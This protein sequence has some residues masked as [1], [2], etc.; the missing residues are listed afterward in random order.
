MNNPA[1]VISAADRLGFTV[2]LATAFHVAIILGIGFALPDAADRPPTL[3]IILAQQETEVAPEKADYLAQ[4]NQ[5][6]SGELEERAAPTTDVEA[7][8]EAEEIQEIVEPEARASTAEVAPPVKQ[9]LAAT[10]PQ[11]EKVSKNPT[12]EQAEETRELDAE[13]LLRRSMEI[14]S[15]EAQLDLQRQQYARN[16]RIRRLTSA[17]TQ[18]ASDAWYLEAWR[19]KIEMVGNL[20]YPDEARR[21]RIYGSLR[22]LVTLK[23]DGSV[24]DIRILESSGHKLLD[25]AAIRIVRLAE[26]FA[27]FPEEM[28][29]DVDVLEVIR[30]WQFR[31]TLTSY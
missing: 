22:M 6:G 14:A 20:N 18:K 26:P 25:E 15:L 12:K 23:P 21:R 19:R 3:E 30:T 28:R 9:V 2:F 27:A 7:E 8:Y 13:T 4:A 11:R 31:R 17:S 29:K 10:S 1:P 16:P 5:E 24:T